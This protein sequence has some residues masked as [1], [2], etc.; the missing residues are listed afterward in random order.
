[1]T[2]SGSVAEPGT[3]YLV[4]IDLIGLNRDRWL[5]VDELATKSR[6][7]KAAVH[8][9][10][11][12]GYDASSMRELGAE[13]GVKAPAIYNHFQSKTDVLAAAIDQ[14]LSNFLLNVLPGLEAFPPNERLF[15][16]LRRHVEYKTSRIAYASALDKLIDREFMH[17]T[18]PRATYD[19][20]TE[21]LGGYRIIVREL[22]IAA[23][24]HVESNPD[25][26]VRVLVCALLEMCDSVSAWF[27]PDGSLTGEAVAAQCC[28]IARR[29]VTA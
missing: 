29:M 7:L 18:L 8:L 13:A 23:A 16:L 5:R 1:M 27:R 17:R 3:R 21:A 15:E 10:A 22:T 19:R 6:L 24:P 11:E 25:V 4:G 9:F 2:A 14:A 28:T 20:F 12:R 26:D